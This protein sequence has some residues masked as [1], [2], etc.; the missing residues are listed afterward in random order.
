MCEPGGATAAQEDPLPTFDDSPPIVPIYKL[1]ST[2]VHRVKRGS[3][4][5]ARRKPAAV[6]APLGLFELKHV[7]APRDRAWNQPNRRPGIGSSLDGNG[8]PC[9]G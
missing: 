2:E 3:T 4:R 9:P 7:L 8:L 6:K 1:P 5:I